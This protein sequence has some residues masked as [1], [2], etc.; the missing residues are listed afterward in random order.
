MFNVLTFQASEP[1]LPISGEWYIMPT[2]N[3]CHSAIDSE[4]TMSVKYKKANAEII[5]FDGANFLMAV[6][7]A[8]VSLIE[9][10][11]RLGCLIFDKDLFSFH[12][13]TFTC[14]KYD[15][16]EIQIVHTH[17]LGGN[18]SYTYTSSDKYTWTCTTYK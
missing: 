5:R 12:G 15:G 3:N 10:A 2:T 8:E 9:Q 16:G 7:S 4:R 11:I 18:G 17:A 1:M 14:G 6:S 13:S